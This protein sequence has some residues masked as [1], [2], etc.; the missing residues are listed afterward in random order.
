[1]PLVLVEQL[2]Q[3]DLQEALDPP[4]PRVRL[5]QEVHREPLERLVGQV[6]P[7]RQV[8]LVPLEYL[9]T[10]VVQVGQVPVVPQ[11]VQAVRGS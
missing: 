9:E 6:P 7:V 11:V 8:T 1:M 3:L 10:L 5:V 2:V 4:V